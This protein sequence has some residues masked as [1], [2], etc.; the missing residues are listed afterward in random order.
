LSDSPRPV[1]PFIAGTLAIVVVA[2]L[3]V[4]AYLHTRNIDE[5]TRAWVV[6]ELQQRFNSEVELQSLHVHVL[7]RM[8][9]T[10]QGLKLRYHNRGDLPPMFQVEKFSFN[11]GVLGILRVPRH[12]A[13]VRLEKMTITI[14]PRG[15]Q[16]K[17][18]NPEEKEIARGKA[19]SIVVDEIICNDTDLVM[20]PKKEGKE[21]LDFDIHNLVLKSVGIDK[22][23][24]FRGSLTNAKPVGEIDTRGTFGPWDADEPGDTPVTGG[25]T[26]THADLGPLPGIAGILSSKGTY[27]GQL[28]EIEVEGETDTPDFSLDK[29]G[30][31]VP[32]H[33][34]YSAT[35][36]G[37]DGD[38]YLHPVRATLIKSLII[39]NGSV[40]RAKGKN[41]H[42]INLDVTSDKARLEDV[43]QLA[44]NTEKPFMTG[45][46]GLKTKLLL[47]PGQVKVLDKLKLEGEFGVT[48]GQWTSAEVREKLGSFSRHAEG[49]PANENA[50]SSVT[51]LRGHFTLD[52]G[53]ITF[54]DLTFSVP[55]AAIQ[56]QGTYN[57]RGEAIDFRG[58]LRLQAKVSQ[59][60]TGAKSFFL[61]AIDPLFEKKGAGALFPISITGTRDAPTVGFTVFHKTI[62]RKIGGDK[63][64]K[65]KDKKQP[66]DDNSSR[67]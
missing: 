60:V 33:T 11:L 34:E 50:G 61:K 63:V 37:T 18:P 12:I 2:A 19:P 35:V 58:E 51:D 66:S 20:V 26:F 47:P 57:L 22:P 3:G 17:P 1:W 32:L 38:T 21:P 4:L 25:Y 15:D 62:E 23:F 53:V 8:G 40:V 46:L 10:G 59:T 41:G 55:G 30:K 54:K 67:R 5:Q 9:V 48:D 28:D 16:K 13:S 24:D 29:V 65:D 42:Y 45:V 43:L 39:A 56:L 36:N 31:R 14:P 44:M 52:D 64:N 49:Q 7:P 6:H 27:K